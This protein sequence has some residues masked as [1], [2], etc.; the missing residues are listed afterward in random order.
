MSRVIYRLQ[1]IPRPR[2]SFS[3]TVTR[4]IILLYL[5]KKK[6]KKKKKYQN[7]LSV[8]KYQLDFFESLP[9]TFIIHFS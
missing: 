6:D 7:H 9:M 5:E 2:L 4:C 3:N 8:R 1:H